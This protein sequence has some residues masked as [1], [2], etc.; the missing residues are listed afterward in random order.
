MGG[1][2]FVPLRDYAAIGDGRT[3][4]L[5]SRDGSVDWLP[6]P[7][8]DSGTV[9]AAV[10]D[11]QRGGRFVLA[12]AADYR[13]Q[14]RYLPGTNV[15]ETTY[16]TAQGAVRVTDAMTLPGP[17]LLP[18][19]ELVRRVEGLSGSVPLRWSV[20]PRFGYAGKMPRMTSRH[21]VPVAASG[22]D[23]VAVSSWQAGEVARTDH[24]ISARFEVRAGERS[25]VALSFTHQEPLVLPTRAECETRL[26]RTVT[27]WREWSHAHTYP[28]PW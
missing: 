13:V 4:A 15:L 25:L 23:A 20:T 14:R 22:A 12:P 27:A 1:V 19:R 3:V 21:G 26:S 17:A 8:L 11:P 5:V 16:L 24:E 7:D 28:G 6:V 10:L 9:F 18:G 2:G